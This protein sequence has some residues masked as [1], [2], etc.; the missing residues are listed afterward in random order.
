MQITYMLFGVQ[1]EYYVNTP[2]NVCGVAANP[3]LLIQRFL[4]RCRH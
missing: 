1:S 3:R 4:V 2:R